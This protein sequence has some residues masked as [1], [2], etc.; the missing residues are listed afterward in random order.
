MYEFDPVQHFDRAHGDAPVN[1]LE[2]PGQQCQAMSHAV[3]PKVAPT[4]DLTNG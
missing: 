3:T 1:G 2:L 4:Q